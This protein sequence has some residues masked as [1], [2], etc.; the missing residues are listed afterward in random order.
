MSSHSTVGLNPLAPMK[1]TT[2]SEFTAKVSV[3]VPV[4]EMGMIKRGK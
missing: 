1:T 3:A 2:A 4:A